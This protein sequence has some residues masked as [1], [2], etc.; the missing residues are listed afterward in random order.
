MYNEEN[1]GGNKIMEEDIKNMTKEEYL[2]KLDMELMLLK[3]Q[4][5][6]QKEIENERLWRQCCVVPKRIVSA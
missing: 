3:L 6:K 2:K 5:I 1:E 4:K